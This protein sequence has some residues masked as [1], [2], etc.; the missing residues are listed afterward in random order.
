[1]SLIRL[2]LS[3]PNLTTP[4]VLWPPVRKAQVPV[5]VVTAF[6]SVALVIVG[7]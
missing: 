6:G 2:P 3:L 5:A 7:F 1:M 4:H